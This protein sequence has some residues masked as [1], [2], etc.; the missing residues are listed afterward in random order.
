MV[1]VLFASLA[2][3]VFA[4][5]KN[6]LE[7]RIRDLTDYFADV[8]KDP[9]KAVP[10][11]ILSKAKGLV[12]MRN[13]KAGFIVGVSGGAGV[14]IVKDKA[15]GEWGPVGF[16]KAGEGSF[17]FQ[18]GAQRSD[19]ILVLMNSDGVKVLTDPNLKLG[20]D[21]RATIGPKSGGDQ[22]NV[23]TDNTPVLVYGDTRGLFGGASIETGGVFPD[24]SDN[25]DY[26]EQKLS[27]NDILIG[28]KVKATEAAKAL[29][30]KIEQYGKVETK[31]P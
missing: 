29:G 19:M 15:T 27:M 16:V 10:A 17:G 25:E 23:K 18:A 26:Y 12:I 6:K 3:A 5:S 24:A 4:A 2:A 7:A 28:G 11:E 20:V 30:A 1:T 8:Q 31:E 21:V 14:A 13:Y 22:A 9:T